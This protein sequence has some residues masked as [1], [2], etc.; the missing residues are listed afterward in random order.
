[1]QTVYKSKIGWES[2]VIIAVV[3]T[4]QLVFF[5]KDYSPYSL[6]IVVPVLGL[7]F[8]IFKNTA[9]TINGNTLNI[10][11][12]FIYNKTIDINTIRKIVETRTPLS[13]PANSL[14][15]LE[16]YYDKFDRVII[17]PKEKEKFVQHL[18]QLNPAITFFPRKK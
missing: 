11:S 6:L 14:D 5:M 13:S 8:H 3:A 7:L 16:V 12:S 18:R 1:M 17:S 4:P 10:K 2:W 15:R 9:Y